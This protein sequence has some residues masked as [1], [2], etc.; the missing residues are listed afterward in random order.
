[1]MC[2]ILVPSF[3]VSGAGGQSWH[4]CGLGT[5]HMSHH[6]PW[7]LG[8]V[9]LSLKLWGCFLCSGGPW[10]APRRML[11]CPCLAEAWAQLTAL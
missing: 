11:L 3:W 9:P 4:H 5:L 1:M 7:S 6:L 8:P 2:H 10:I